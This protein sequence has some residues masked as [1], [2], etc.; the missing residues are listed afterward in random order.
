MGEDRGG[1]ALRGTADGGISACAG[2]L[3]RSGYGGGWDA[4]ELF[5]APV[6]NRFVSSHGPGVPVSRGLSGGGSF[7]VADRGASTW[8]SYLQMEGDRAHPGRFAS[9]VED[10]W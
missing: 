7:R 3:T 1:T 10:H 6:S 4:R 2:C 5:S 9:D 8:Q